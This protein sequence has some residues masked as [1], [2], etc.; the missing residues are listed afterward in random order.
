[1][2]RTARTLGLVVSLTLASPAM[3][4]LPHP[5]TAD[6]VEASVTTVTLKTHNSRA[7]EILNKALGD[8]FWGDAWVKDY[9]ERLYDTLRLKS[10]PDGFVP[11]IAGES[12]QDLPRGVVGDIIY[13]QN[14]RLPKYMS[15]AKAVVDL[16]K[17]IDE[18]TGAQ[19]RD[20]YYVLDLTLFYGT[21][22]QRMYRLED[23]DNG[24]TIL[25]FEKLEPSFTDAGTWS[26]YQAKMTELDE[27]IDTRW[28]FN[29]FVP[30][31]EVFGMFIVEPGIRRESRVT[32]ISKLSF[33]DD[34]GWVA[35]WGSQLPGVIKA[36]L[37][38]GYNACVAI[39]KDEHA[40][41]LRNPKPAPA[42]APEAAPEAETEAEAPPA[43]PGAE[44]PPPAKPAP[45]APTAPP[46]G[47]AGG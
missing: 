40:R 30:F 27:S 33:G 44:T 17:G 18:V 22:P 7:N 25:W 31:G 21:Y 11:M 16:G 41:R 43:A 1:M 8:A 13:V 39:A 46:A 19:Y 6:L 3:A 38:S 45:V 4:S 35:K 37:K 15:G 24:R 12:D 23:D 32:F 36:G 29:A 10:L 9:D 14:T 5:V 47:A 42:P 26:R 20:S 28:A 2:V 34:A